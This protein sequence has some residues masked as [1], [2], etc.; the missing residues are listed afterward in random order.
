MFQCKS[1]P[2][3]AIFSAVLLLPTATLALDDV[4][5]T[6]LSTDSQLGFPGTP[7]SVEITIQFTPVMSLGLLEFGGIA[8]SVPNNDPLD[9]FYGIGNGNYIALNLGFATLFSARTKF[10]AFPETPSP[11][12]FAGIVI[13]AGGQ[14][15]LLATGSIVTYC[16]NSMYCRQSDTTLTGLRY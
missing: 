16:G 10:F 11:S 13:S 15:Y 1:P 2:A 7:F 8:T 14:Q 3:A 6:T 5:G 9:D 4:Y 12:T